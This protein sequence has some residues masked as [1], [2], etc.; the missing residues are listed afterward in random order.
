ML[1]DF[2]PARSILQIKLQDEDVFFERPLSLDDFRVE[3]MVPALP[4]LLA[5]T[6]IQVAS[7]PGPVLG[8]IAEDQRAQELILLPRPRSADHMAPITELQI[9]LVTLYLRLANKLANP[10]PRIVAI[11]SNKFQESLVLSKIDHQ[12]INQIESK[13]ALAKQIE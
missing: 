6:A 9:A 11:D 8:S 7:D 12:H 5:N 4:T 1:L 10:T 2:T 3:V 13:S